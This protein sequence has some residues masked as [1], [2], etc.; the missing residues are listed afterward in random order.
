MSTAPIVKD[1]SASV[2]LAIEGERGV[3]GASHPR[4]EKVSRQSYSVP[5]RE[6]VPTKMDDSRL[7]VLAQRRDELEEC[8][9]KQLEA[10]GFGLEGLAVQVFLDMRYAGQSYELAI[11]SE[12]LAPG[13]FLPA[14][15]AAHQ[16][17]FGHSDPWRAVEVINLRVK[18]LLP[19]IGTRSP[20]GESGK[21][22][23]KPAAASNQREVWF[24]GKPAA[25]A[26]YDRDDLL[27]GF[28]LRG[29]AVVVQMDSTTALPPGWQGEVGET[30][31]L[32][33]TAV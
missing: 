32:I 31:N 24:E 7:R 4:S 25:T 21:R 23:A 15:H 16:T 6:E 29:P 13:D 8:G 27:P 22:K 12:S 2:M 11:P 9:R 1:I 10:E 26:V 20:R 5:Q 33:L 18:L 3:A 14:F 17:R 19:G 30:G 28:R